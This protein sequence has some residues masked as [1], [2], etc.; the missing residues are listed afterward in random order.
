MAD[1]VEDQLRAALTR[2]EELEV[3]LITTMPGTN[4]NHRECETRAAAAEQEVVRLR[5]AIVAWCDAVPEHSIADTNAS[6]FLRTIAAEG[7]D[8]A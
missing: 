2:I 7:K 6:V 1:S 8:N 3:E 5:G 4:N